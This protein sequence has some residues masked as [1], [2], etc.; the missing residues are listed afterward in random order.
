MAKKIE[1]WPAV[2]IDTREQTPWTFTGP[3]CA[4]LG[5]S[6]SSTTRGTLCTGDYALAEAPDL[7]RIERKTLGDFCGSVTHDHERFLREIDRL[8]AFPIAAVIVEAG[9]EEVVRGTR[10][11]SPQSVIASALKIMADYRV[12]VIWGVSR[13]WAEYQG[14]WMLRRAWEKRAVP[15]TWLD[16]LVARSGELFAAALDW[17]A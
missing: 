10:Q 16:R 1:T 9:M 17:S 7:C 3:T 13:P 2:I 5:V 4:Q 8:A 6:I 15:R 14:A 11:A 12:P